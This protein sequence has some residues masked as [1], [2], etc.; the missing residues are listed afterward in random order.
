MRNQFT[1][2]G[3]EVFTSEILTTYKKPLEEKYSEQALTE[4]MAMS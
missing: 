2:L 4:F 3:A 1:K